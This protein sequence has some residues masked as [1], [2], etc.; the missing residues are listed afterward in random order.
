MAQKWVM[1]YPMIDPQGNF[2]SVD[3]DPPA[4]Y[5]YTEARLTALAETLLADIE[6]DTV[7]FAPNY[8]ESTTEPTVLPSA[9]PNL[10]MNGSTGIAVGMATNIPPHNLDE[11]IA[12]ICAIIE[13]P[14]I[15]LEEVCGFIQGPD[16]PTGG[17]IVGTAGIDSYLRTGRGIVRMRGR[18]HTE[19]MKAGGEQIIITEIPY[20]VNRANLVLK[21]AELVSDK[22]IEGIRDLRDESDENTRIVIELKRGEQAE[23]IL[24][25][26][27]KRTAL[28]SSFGVNLLALDQKRPKQMNIREL[29]DCYIEHRREVITRRTQFRLRKAEDRAHILEGYKIALDNL[30]DFVRIIRASSN[31]AE[32]KIKLMEKYPLSSRQTDAILE[33]R[34]YQLTGLERD[35]IE[36]EYAQLIRL[37]EEL[38]AILES[39]RLLLDVIKSELV[40]A[41]AKY[42]NPRKCEVAPDMG[43]FRM[44]DVIPNEGMVITISH[45]G[46]I[47]R[48]RVADFRSQKRGGK[49]VI[50]T[51]TYSDDFVEHLFTAQ[52]H[53]YILFITSHGQCLARKV[54]QIPEGSRVSK[55]KSVKS[56]LSLDDGEKIAAMLTHS[57]FDEE[58][59]LVMATKS[60]QIK[61]TALAAY[62]NATRESGLIGIN[63]AEG[64]S[65]IGCVLT[66]G[67][68]EVILVSHQG[69]AVRFR[70]K[71][72]AGEVLFRATGRATSGVTGMR[73]KRQG[74][75]LQAIE[76]VDHEKKFL[77]ASEAGLGVRTRFEDYRLIH[78]GGTG[79]TAINLPDDGSVQLVGALGVKD[80]DEIMLLTSKGQSVRCPIN[81]VRETNRGAKGV[82]LLTLAKGDT[83]LSLAKVVES[84][85]ELDAAAAAEGEIEPD[86]TLDVTAVDAPAG[87]VDPVAADDDT[88]DLPPATE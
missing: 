73:F 87:N 27:Y 69:L 70:E 76:V 11:L 62:T 24:N 71:N 41:G 54:Y 23:P 18:A 6:E 63:L 22:T 5:R 40:E 64:D 46:F 47:K 61:K 16:F 65:V 52:T 26:L 66:D 32:A 38:R 8:K 39:E 83:L 1:R 85:E 77:V 82:K 12:A 9:L 44:E 79:V 17:F 48:T 80:T 35:K 28:E 21:I 58:H 30:D 25:Q 2:G 3:G 68:S 37:I 51:D 74:D 88:T 20:N 67:A 72:E 50:G 42:S 45:S 43:E 57:A 55:G 15:T 59:F 75:Y 10:L 36:E 4:A 34:L 33:L 49:G 84:D 86:D 19:E 7:D 60:G 13:R 56:F 78:R 53:D 14:D 81:T 31:R 29:L